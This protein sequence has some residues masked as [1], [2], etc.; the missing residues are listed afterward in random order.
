MAEKKKDKQ[1]KPI[2]KTDKDLFDLLL[3][4]IAS[5]EYAFLRHAKQRQKDRKITD[6][7]VLDIL[8]GTKG[9]DRHRNKAKDKYEKNKQDWNYCIEGENLDRDK[10]RVIISFEN[11]LVPIITVMR[12]KSA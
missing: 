1:K 3:R 11:G 6:L 12:I 9:R 4:K 8:E 2:K 5:R 10:I 7:E